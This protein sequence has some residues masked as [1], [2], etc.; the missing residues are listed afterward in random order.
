M[1]HVEVESQKQWK[2]QKLDGE[3]A[4]LLARHGFV[5]LFTRTKK[6]NNAQANVIYAKRALADRFGSLRTLT[7]FTAFA[8]K[9]R[10]EQLSGASTNLAAT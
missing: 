9:R 2:D 4:E 5:V 10:A 8:A 7:A 1:I 6:S 3:I